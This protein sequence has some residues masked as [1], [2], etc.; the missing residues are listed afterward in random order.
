MH[1]AAVFYLP[2]HANISTHTH[3]RTPLHVYEMSLRW[4]P[5]G[6]D[7]VNLSAF[8]ASV[9]QRVYKYC[10]KRGRAGGA[11]REAKKRTNVAGF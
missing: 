4:S 1:F 6:S 2:R 9:T 5:G 3:T 10:G 8:S 7:W 11:G